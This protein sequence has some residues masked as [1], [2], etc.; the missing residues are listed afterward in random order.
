M[1]LP[2]LFPVFVL[3]AF[4]GIL[5]TAF[6]RRSKWSAV[7]WTSLL[8]SAISVMV[9]TFQSPPHLEGGPGG[10]SAFGLIPNFI[11]FGICTV[12]L[13][14]LLIFHPAGDVLGSAWMLTA[15]IPWALIAYLLV[16]VPWMWGYYPLKI[17]VVDW[18]NKPLV[19][20]KIH[21]LEERTGISL[22]Q[23]F[24]SDDVTTNL[25]TDSAGNVIYQ[26]NNYR[27]IFGAVNGYWQ[28]PG[29]KSLGNSSFNLQPYGIGFYGNRGDQKQELQ[30]SWTGKGQR[31]GMNDKF[32]TTSVP[33]PYTGILTIFL[34][35][36]GGE[37]ESPYPPAQDSR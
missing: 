23:A 10:L 33:R 27:K 25:T 28:D 24:L 21:F 12:I 19:G 5:A 36:I 31:P 4:C 37:D 7:I 22:D 3:V 11:V 29:D 26:G 18:Q 30:I 2:W 16:S 6:Y 32:Y 1:M 15:V 9:I 34:P 13:I 17:H 20:V 8:I 14:V 35:G